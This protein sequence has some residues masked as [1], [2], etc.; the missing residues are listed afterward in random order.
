MN[1]PDQAPNDPRQ[2]D[3]F[4]RL[5]T[6]LLRGQTLETDEPMLE[7]TARF[8]RQ[9][10]AAAHQIQPRPTF[11]RQL[12]QQLLH[13]ATEK[14]QKKPWRSLWWERWQGSLTMKRTAYSLAGLAAVVVIA[15]VGWSL[16]NNQLGRPEEPAAVAVVPTEAAQPAQPAPTEAASTVTEEMA[17]PVAEP[18][19]A[20]LPVPTEA[21]VAGA[22]GD[23][24]SIF[25]GAI[26]SERA[27]GGGGGGEGFGGPFTN[28]T[29]I[30]D[31]TLPTI[32]RATTYQLPQTFDQP[33]DL[34]ALRAW[35]AKFGVTGDVYF[36]WYAGM[37]ADGSG[38]PGAYRIFAGDR[39]VTAYN[40]GEFI[41]E[42]LRYNMG[43]D[44]QPL[45]FAESAAIA[46]RLVT[47]LGLLDVPYVQR[48][49]WGYEVQYLLLVDGYPVN[50]PILS[51]TISG[52]GDV[53]T[54]M[55]RP[56]ILGGAVGET[57]L[58]SAAEA[59]AFIQR[60]QADGQIYF[61]LFPVNPAYYMPSGAGGQRT[62]WQ[63]E[64]VP[65]EEIAMFSWIQVFRKA[66]G[67]GEPLLLTDRNI[68]LLAD[69][70]VLEQMADIA[71]GGSNLSLRGTLSGEPGSLALNV[72]AFEPVTGP[73]DLYLGGSSRLE[74]GV[75]YLQVPGGYRFALA[76][77]PDD[78]PLDTD[79]TVYSWGIRPDERGLPILDWTAIDLWNVP[80]AEGPDFAE[81]DPYSGVTGVTIDRVD[82]GYQ[83]IYS[84]EVTIG[85]TMPY[86][87]GGSE[88]HLVPAWFF[89]GT[90]NKGDVI[91]IIVP[92][93][94]EIELQ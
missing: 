37:P 42:D 20:P 93:T 68:R 1:Q 6:A 82:L 74:G 50:M 87:P 57:T 94:T 33:I 23:A 22:G 2:A 25:P 52:R 89:T 46:D 13:K 27:M 71:A 84:G 21:P 58:R 83:I 67:S 66:D 55:Y 31:A 10:V 75:V 14:T 61:N 88:P 19:A 78:L 16:F 73:S 41:F 32:E 60:H 69:R 18:P 53:A 36:D 29:L 77:A 65:G 48:R 81:I 54:V 26:Q 4:D 5:L 12:R 64:L 24:T 51:I 59:W 43:F 70:G 72:T 7:E 56:N 8:T 85:S 9:L 76:N 49:G 86:N 92:A 39:R 15:F 79:M 28:A 34:E 17:A 38:Q 40:G 45:P 35:A 3:E 47:E 91:E 80:Y 90:T 63:R 11:K 44:T 30:L 62:H